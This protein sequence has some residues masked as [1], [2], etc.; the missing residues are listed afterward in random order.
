MPTQIHQP[1]GALAELADEWHPYAR[2]NEARN[3]H[4]LARGEE[5]M[6]NFETAV[7]ERRGRRRGRKGRR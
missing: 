5:Q 7:R 4:T 3:P 2:A 1:A 6:G